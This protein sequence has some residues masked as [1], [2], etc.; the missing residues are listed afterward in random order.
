MTLKTI[1]NVFSCSHILWVTIL[2]N[3]WYRSN[4]KTIS[5]R[6]DLNAGEILNYEAI[7]DRQPKP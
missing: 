5:S 6:K 4:N 7:P 3:V 1:Y 2:P